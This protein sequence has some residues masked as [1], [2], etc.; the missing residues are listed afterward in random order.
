MLILRYSVV[1]STWASC[2]F[3]LNITG[4]DQHCSATGYTTVGAVDNFMWFGE[5]HPSERA[6]QIIAQEFAKVVEGS[7]AYATY[8]SSA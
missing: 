1:T 3:P 5:L 8:W 7:S 6:D 4:F 2:H